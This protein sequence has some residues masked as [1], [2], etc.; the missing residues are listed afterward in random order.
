MRTMP[1]WSQRRRTL[2]YQ[3]AGGMGKPAVA[4]IVSM[5]MAATSSVTAASRVWKSPE[6]ARREPGARGRQ[7]AG[8]GEG[9]CGG[10]GGGEFGRALCQGGGVAA[11]QHVVGHVDLVQGVLEGGDD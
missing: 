6:G 10:V 1:R 4:G 5:M 7:R 11:G 2:G 9:G 8:G 3:S